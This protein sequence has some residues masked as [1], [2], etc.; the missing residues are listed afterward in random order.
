[1]EREN[2]GE[3]SVAGGGG[4]EWILLGCRFLLDSIIIEKCFRT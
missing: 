4:V 2:D 1:M 3:W